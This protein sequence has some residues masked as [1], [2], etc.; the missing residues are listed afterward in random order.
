LGAI[1]ITTMLIVYSITP[2]IIC[3]IFIAS[4]GTMIISPAASASVLTPFPQS[5]GS[6]TALMNAI[7]VGGSAI[8]ASVIGLLL[9]SSLY[10]YPGIIIICAMGILITL[11]K[12]K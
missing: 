4:L 5:A 11:I 2:E 12:V 1:G 7:R 6:V 8:T 10:V 3:P 9:S